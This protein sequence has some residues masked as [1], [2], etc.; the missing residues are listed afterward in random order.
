MLYPLAEEIFF[1]GHAGSS[2]RLEPADGLL[3]SA[4]LLV[5]MC[6]IYDKDKP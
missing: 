5:I 6:I 1:I 2:F 4:A 3:A